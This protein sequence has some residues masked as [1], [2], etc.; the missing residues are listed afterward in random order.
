MDIRDT[1]MNKTKF[2]PR[3]KQPGIDNI[4]NL[5]QMLREMKQKYAQEAMGKQARVLSLL[6]EGGRPRRNQ[7]SLAVRQHNVGKKR[8]IRETE[9]WKHCPWSLG[10]RGRRRQQG[11]AGFCVF[12]NCFILFVMLK[13]LHHITFIEN[14]H[15]KIYH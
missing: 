14:T 7:R 9:E 5:T 4:D 15:F 6:G 10:S 8:Y 11:I 2:F 12:F 1:K 13:T 3:R